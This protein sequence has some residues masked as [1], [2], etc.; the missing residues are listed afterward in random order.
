MSK[1]KK[2]QIKSEETKQKYQVINWKSYNAAL[3]NR[4]DISLYFDEE[5]LVHWYSDSP[6]QRGA[7]EVY[8]DLCIETILLLNLWV[9]IPIE[10]ETTTFSSHSTRFLP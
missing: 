3:I 5:V 2:D 8:S 6:A 10:A 1:V 7:Q 4:G 9:G